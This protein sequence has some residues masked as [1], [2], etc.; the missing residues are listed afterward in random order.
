MSQAQY[1]NRRANC[2]IFSITILLLISGSY[3]LSAQ[4]KFSVSGGLGYY[5]LTNVGIHWNSSAASSFSIYGGSNFGMGNT[6]YLS[7]GFSFAHVYQKPLFW[8]IKAG[9]S[10]GIIYWT[11]DDDL[12]N[13]TNLGLPLMALL[14]YPL[15]KSF[16]IRAEGGIIFNAVLTS[17]RKQN[18][19]AGY[20]ERFNGNAALSIIY[21]FGSK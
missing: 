16:T 10:I 19:E 13:F 11:S 3:N 9:Y 15:S 12:Y 1:K 17:D 20:P 8:D 6:S 2:R 5:E 7:L 18:T 21:K 4:D 14:E